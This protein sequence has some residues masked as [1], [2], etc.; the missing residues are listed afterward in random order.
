MLTD[1]PVE[2][3]ESSYGLGLGAALS[4]PGRPEHGMASRSEALELV[5]R[6]CSG[7]EPQHPKDT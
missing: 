7:C 3:R 4:P 6:V 5:G 1:D 2:E